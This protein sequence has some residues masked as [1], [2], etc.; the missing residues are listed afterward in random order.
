MHNET[1]DISKY[2][3]NISKNN[4]PNNQKKYYL[5]PGNLNLQQR[6]YKSI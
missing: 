2:I 5:K 6:L 4:S 3:M 1:T